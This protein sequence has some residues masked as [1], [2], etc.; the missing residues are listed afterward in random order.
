LR[1]ED[2]DRARTVETSVQAIVDSLRWL[3]IDW[4]EGPEVGGPHAPYFQSQRLPLYTKAAEALMEKGRAYRCFCTSERLDAMRAAQQA[5]K[6]PPGY[7]GLCRT[8]ADEESLRRAMREPFVIRFAMKKVGTTVLHD[9]IRGDI[10]FE[11]ALQDDFVILKTDG[12]PT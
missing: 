4:D 3:G 2:T 11:N 5:A 12:Y 8:M 9:V 6:Q 7:D 10:S 1:I